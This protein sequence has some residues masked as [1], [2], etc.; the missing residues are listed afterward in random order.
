[1]GAEM[2]CFS[3]KFQRNNE[4]HEEILKPEAS[5]LLGEARERRM[6]IKYIDELAKQSSDPTIAKAYK[7]LSNSINN[8]EHY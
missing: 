5:E 6:V 3:D 4:S 1:M 2:L 7:E 8:C